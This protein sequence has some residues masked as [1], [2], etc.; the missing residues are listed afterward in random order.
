MYKFFLGRSNV[1][2]PSQTFY[3]RQ[4]LTCDARTGSGKRVIAGGNALLSGNCNSFPC[5]FARTSDG[6]LL[7]AN[8]MGVVR[9][10]DGQQLQAIPAGVI[11]PTVAPTMTFNEVQFKP[12]GGKYN[13]QTFTALQA[14]IEWEAQNR[15]QTGDTS[16]PLYAGNQ[17]AYDAWF[18]TVMVGTYSSYVRF[19]DRYGNYSNLSP[20]SNIVTVGRPRPDNLADPAVLQA[21]NG[22]STGL[23]PQPSSMIEMA[24]TTVTYSNVPVPTESRVIRRQILRNTAGQADTY[25]V[26]VDTTDLVST[27]FT[28]TNADPTLAVQEA[29]PLFDLY[30]FPLA[31]RF[32]IPPNHKPYLASYGGRMFLAGDR[33]YTD[34]SIQVTLGSPTV[35]GIGTAWTT[36]MVNRFLYVAGGQQ[37]YQIKSVSESAQTLTLFNNYAEATDSFA[38]YAIRVAPAERRILYFSGVG[39]PESWSAFDG[40]SLEDRGD[41]ITGML[42]RSG[43][44][45]VFERRHVHRFTAKS[46]PLLDGGFFQV[47]ERGVVDQRCL[48]EV[49]DSVYALDYRGVYELTGDDTVNEI[50]EAIQ[51]L[52]RTDGEGMRISWCNPG[53]FHAVHDPD[54]KTIRF[55]VT[56]G[57]CCEPHHAITYHYQNKRWWIE[58]YPVPMTASCTAYL[59]RP[60]AF[61]GVGDNTYLLSNLVLDGVAPDAGTLSGSVTSASA[62]QFTD[63]AATFPAGLVGVPVAITGGQG[64][65]QLRLI[66]AVSGQTITVD[67]PF[68][69]SLSTGSGPPTGPQST[70]Q[71]GGIPWRWR[72]GWMR[73]VD[74]EQENPRGIRVFFA[75]LVNGGSMDFRTYWDNGVVANQMGY[76]NK[77][78]YLSILL[79]DPDAVIDLKSPTGYVFIHRDGGMEKNINRPS[80][81]QIEL[82]GFGVGEQVVVH[83]LDLEGVVGDMPGGGR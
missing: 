74:E 19:V 59:P 43:F 50:G 2:S 41:E 77:Q 17:N 13:N 58:E 6:V 80:N 55:F 75:P 16:T 68:I 35:T 72:T 11:A 15:L 34:G 49:G 8:G 42:N 38:L 66:T 14:A 21:L 31:N 36:A 22:A 47:A 62:L 9:R 28:S 45:Y 4:S 23:Y 78:D 44:L 64:K 54:Q 39:L 33:S 46:N 37:G 73:F 32:G 57:G 52:F 18:N 61:T 67:R 40:L 3:W 51:D 25:Y 12:P 60:Y 69:P 26:D 1:P 29:Q 71:I 56:L 81:L 10:W 27:T 76:D 79:N 30:G 7:I 48:V 5:S 53:A 63:S 24:A 65:N 82:R 83:E 20:L 70:Y